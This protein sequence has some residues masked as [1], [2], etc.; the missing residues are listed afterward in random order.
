MSAGS[1]GH[2]TS[3]TSSGRCRSSDRAPSSPVA[4]QQRP[5]RGGRGA[6]GCAAGRRRWR[7]RRA[8]RRQRRPRR[9]AS[10][11]MSGWSASPTTIGVV[12]LVWPRVDRRAAATSAWPSAQR[13]FC[14][15]RH[16]VGQ[17]ELDRAGDDDRL[18][19][20][21]AERRA[22]RP[23]VQRPASERRQQLVLGAGEPAAAAGGEH[24]GRVLTPRHCHRPR[25][26][27]RSH[28][29]DVTLSPCHHFLATV[30]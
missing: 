28:E 8:S 21:G 1:P 19:E 6:P 22:R 9:H 15:P 20:P 2:A 16:A 3:V 14:E 24:D 5:D 27:G 25:H 29:R 13:V 26:L 30:D 4:G 7:R 17:V 23:T 10:A 18:V 11:G 12:A